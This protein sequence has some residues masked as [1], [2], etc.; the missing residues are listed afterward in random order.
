AEEAQQACNNLTHPTASNYNDLAKAF[1][2]MEE[3][4]EKVMT[5]AEQS[6]KPTNQRQT[7]S[8]RLRQKV[9]G[10]APEGHGHQGTSASDDQHGD[11]EQIVSLNAADPSLQNLNHLSPEIVK[12]IQYLIAKQSS[13]AQSSGSATKER[14]S[15][16]GFFFPLNWNIGHLEDVNNIAE[17]IAEGVQS[18]L[19]LSGRAWNEK[20]F[21][22]A[23]REGGK[24]GV[25]RAGQMFTVGLVSSAAVAA[26]VP[27]G[28]AVLC[29]IA[30]GLSTGLVIEVALKA[31][32]DRQLT[33]EEWKKIHED[34]KICSKRGRFR[35][36]S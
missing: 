7:P 28:L 9:V 18:W 31:N 10:S 12:V 5:N 21:M 27:L 3:E 11:V 23:V 19:K 14:G 29:R 26:G 4:I 32:E 35:M 8:N 24:I 25:H 36:L 33:P 6:Q 16:E 22:A 13:N 34:L 20:G 17:E 2:N 15:I 30:M 1:K